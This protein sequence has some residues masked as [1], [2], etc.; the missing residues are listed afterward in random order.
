MKERDPNGYQFN[1]IFLTAKVLPIGI[2]HCEKF[3]KALSY[4]RLSMPAS[5]K[6]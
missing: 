2:N 4:L 3:K 5:Q 1:T 6:A